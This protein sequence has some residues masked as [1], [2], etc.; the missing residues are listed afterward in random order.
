MGRDAAKAQG[1]P[2]Y[3]ARMEAAKYN[4]KL[5]SREGAAEVTGIGAEALSNYERGLCK[6]IP[7]ESAVILADTYNAPHL[8]NWYCTHECPIGRETMRSV[9]P[10]KPLEQSTIQISR[11]MR[12]TQETKETLEDI[13]ADGHIT[14]EEWS[15]LEEVLNYFDDLV[16]TIEEFRTNVRAQLISIHAP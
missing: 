6:V 4:D 9:D 1:N 10:T 13:M 11:L 14:A 15:Q 16:A 5:G 7:V 3:Q 2:W 12:K 8:T